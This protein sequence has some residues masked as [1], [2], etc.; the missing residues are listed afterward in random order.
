MYVYPV[1]TLF[2]LR[3]VYMVSVCHFHW[4]LCNFFQFR[5]FKSKLK[6]IS[7]FFYPPFSPKTL[8]FPSQSCTLSF[9]YQYWVKFSI[10]LSF[11]LHKLWI[12]HPP[13]LHHFTSN[14]LSSPSPPQIHCTRGITFSSVFL[15]EVVC[16]LIPLVFLLLILLSQFAGFHN[17]FWLL[18][19]FVALA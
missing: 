9:P 4:L 2:I 11:T 8:S 5:N 15:C 18:L 17:F 19:E 1:D 16:Y 6:F 3:Q 12:F 10:A 7:A 13:M 14:I